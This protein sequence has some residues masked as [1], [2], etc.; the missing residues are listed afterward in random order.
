MIDT[1]HIGKL[2]PADIREAWNH[3][4][5]SFTPW[6]YTNLAELGEAIGLRLEPEGSEVRVGTF[7]ADIL[8]RNPL[9]DSRIL[10]ENQLAGS[11]HGHLGQILTYLAGLEAKV[12]VWVATD[13]RE[14]HLSALRWLNMH[15]EPEFSFFAVKVRVVRIGDSPFAPIFD[16]LERPNNWE[17]QLHS[18]AA[19]GERSELSLRRYDFWQAFIDRVPG[20]LERGGPASYWSNRWHVLDDLGLIISMY[21]GKESVGIFIR[22]PQQRSHDDTREMIGLKEVELAEK[23]GTPMGTSSSHF[24]AKSVKGDYTDPAQ[25]DGLIDW[26]AV[27]AEVYE[28]ALREVFGGQ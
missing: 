18:A 5:H 12:I 1:P 14:E 22:G 24:F 10:I 9:D 26:L 13:F 7:C 3:E 23:I 6:L 21:P 28:R 16:V 4:A 20:E 2:I 15:T 25:R 27:Q 8:A 11:D 17:R 19:A